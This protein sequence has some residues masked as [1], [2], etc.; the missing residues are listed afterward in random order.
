[1]SKGNW[2]RL[3]V[4]LKPIQDGLG[5]R[6]ILAFCQKLIAERSLLRRSNPSSK[7]RKSFCGFAFLII[8][9]KRVPAFELRA[10]DRRP[11]S[12]K[13]ALHCVRSS[14]AAKSE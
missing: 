3:L 9:E 6:P 7:G 1:M 4:S 2:Y 12:A 14:D 8:G 13:P 5:S 10:F 11:N